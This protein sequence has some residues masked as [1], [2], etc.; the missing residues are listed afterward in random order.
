MFAFGFSTTSRVYISILAFFHMV[1]SQNE[2]TIFSHFITN[3]NH[4]WI[5]VWLPTLEFNFIFACAYQ[6]FDNWSAW[7]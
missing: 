1:K 5:R 2:K 3:W 7:H 6:N 4:A